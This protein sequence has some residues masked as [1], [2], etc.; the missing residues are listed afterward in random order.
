MR[1]C[2]RCSAASGTTAAA[3]LSI[4]PRRLIGSIRW[5]CRA[6]CCR[7]SA[8]CHQQCADRSVDSIGQQ[9]TSFGMSASFA[10]KPIGSDLAN[11]P[12]CLA[13]VVPV[14][15]THLQVP[16]VQQHSLQ[17]TLRYDAT[18]PN[19]CTTSS[20]QSSSNIVTPAECCSARTLSSLPWQ[21]V[22]ASTHAH[23]IQTRRRF[24]LHTRSK[25]PT[26]KLLLPRL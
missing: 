3:V 20:Y 9:R 6:C 19:Q 26:P 5:Q 16:D 1:C 12:A 25:R 10:K 4:V 7:H 11:V 24:I 18:D 23:A 2:W 15:P 22:A 13:F 8:K 17:Q 21:I 14:P